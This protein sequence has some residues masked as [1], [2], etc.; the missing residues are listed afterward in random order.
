MGLIS[1][2]TIKLKKKF[3]LLKS[4]LKLDIQHSPEGI[5]SLHKNTE[6]MLFFLRLKHINICKLGNR[7]F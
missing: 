7:F 1:F 2:K 5:L 3:H 6:G 4:V